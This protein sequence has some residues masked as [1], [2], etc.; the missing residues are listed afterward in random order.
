MCR[1]DENIFVGFPLLTDSYF[2]SMNNKFKKHVL[3]KSSFLRGNNCN[4]SL[5]LYKNRRDLI[6]ATSAGQQFIFDQGHE[7]G[8]LAQQLFPGGTDAS[9]ATPYDYQPSIELTKKLIAEGK[10][11]I[12]EAAFQYDGVLAALDI[13][14]KVEDGWHAY[15]VK[16]STKVH[17]INI[18]DAAL[19]FLVMTKCGIDLKDMS[20]IHIDNEYER[21]GEIEPAKL[22]KTESVYYL[23]VALQDEI[24][25]QVKELKKVAARKSCPSVLIGK[26]CSNPYTCDFKAFCW[27]DVP[28][29]SILDF[30][31][32]HKTE[33]RFKQY[34]AGV[35]KIVSVPNWNQLRPPYNYVV[36]S[37]I[38]RGV[39]LDPEP[40]KEF[41][42]GMIYPIHFLD[43]ET[44]RFAVPRLQLTNPYEQTPF[45]YSL[46]ISETLG[47]EPV[48]KAFLAEPGKDFREDF[49]VTLLRDLG[50][51]GSILV[52]NIGFER[53][54]LKHFSILFPQYEPQI[55]AA[56]ERMIDLAVPFQKKWFYHYLFSCSY[57]IKQVLPVVAPELSYKNLAVNNGDDASVLFMRMMAEPDKDWSAERKN[58]LEY[59]GLDTMAM[60]VIHR[61]LNKLV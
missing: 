54:K 59:C 19:Q 38:N 49:L 57:S 21:N 30:G 53:S 10:Q 1:F 20:V 48:S 2:Y 31:Y 55:N 39:Y 7:V 35:T 44:V 34:H 5:W 28:D 4:K 12:Y 32:Y 23:V 26:Q 15:E 56:I 50:T 51:E 24:A 3:S 41:L 33:E 18:T 58:L 13:L 14:V 42:D 29:Q 9:P 46:H 8:V 27:K 6:P 36:E 11:V 40:V 45:Q 17:D 43:F 52:W 61:F 16:S 37:H 60:V 47:A 22:F 25:R